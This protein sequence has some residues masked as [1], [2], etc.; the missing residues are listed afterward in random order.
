M[1]ND[2]V[3]VFGASG[4]V[5]SNFTQ[6]E[7]CYIQSR[8]DLVPE[9]N[10]ILWLISTLSNYNVF[11]DL[12]IDINTNQ[13]LLMKMLGNAREKFGED[14][15]VN[16]VSTWFI[17]GLGET[18]PVK[19]TSPCNPS[20]FYSI[21]KYAAE[22]L[23]KSYC[24]TFGI[25]YRILRLANVIG[26]G[27]N[28]TSYK[29]KAVQFMISELMKGNKVKLYREVSIRDF[30]DIRDCVRAIK[31]VIDIGEYN[32]TYNIGNGEP[33]SVNDLIYKAREFCQTGEIYEVPAPSFHQKVQTREFWMDNSK[34]KSLGYR[35][36]YSYEDTLIW[37]I[38]G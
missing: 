36:K 12:L 9:T 31:L 16:Y 28:G 10:N 14:F 8:E 2:T 25:K 11:D 17:Y 24:A 3:S 35:K 7:N 23:L 30:I 18:N 29:K 22:Q 34:L 21:T 4:F 32:A 15:C 20:G 38:N 1:I 13:I 6:Q 27:D 33:I 26:R 37:M 19:E 5:G